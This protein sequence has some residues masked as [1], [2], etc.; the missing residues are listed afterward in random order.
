MRH[1]HRK[2]F[3][4]IDTKA[5]EVLQYVKTHNL[6]IRFS[7]EDSFRSD[8]AEILQLYT[9]VDRLGVDHVG[10]A[11]IVGSATAREV[12]DKSTALRGIV[13]CE[14]RDSFPR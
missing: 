12:F 10:I 11:D 6:E 14:Y 1:S 3:V 2:D 5:K 13:G 8:F 4:H 9:T 7:G